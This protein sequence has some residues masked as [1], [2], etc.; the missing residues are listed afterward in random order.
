MGMTPD[1]VRSLLDLLRANKAADEEQKDRPG[2]GQ[3]HEGRAEA[4]DEVITLIESTTRSN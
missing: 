3:H 1:Q 4:F 2:L